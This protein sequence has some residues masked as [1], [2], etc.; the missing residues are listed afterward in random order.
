MTF[1]GGVRDCSMGTGWTPPWS[2]PGAGSFCLLRGGVR[3]RPVGVRL[4][5]AALRDARWSLLGFHV[6]LQPRR[7]RDSG[8]LSFCPP[9]PPRPAPPR[10]P[11][12]PGCEGAISVLFGATRIGRKTPSAKVS[13]RCSTVLWVGRS[14]DQ[15]PFGFYF[16]PGPKGGRGRGGLRGT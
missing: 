2:A 8:V 16:A 6:R 9:A 12:V 1:E 15:E 11:K 13:H 5:S 14:Q 7:E 3:F 4:A 10:A